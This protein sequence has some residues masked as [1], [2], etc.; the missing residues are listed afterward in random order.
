MS[1]LCLSSFL[2]V[3]YGFGDGSLGDGGCNEAYSA[4][5]DTVFRA[6]ATTFVSLTWFALFLAWE[7]VSARRSFFLARPG[8]KHRVTQWARDAWRNRFLFW[9]IVAGFVTVFPTIY[10]PVLNHRVFKH[11][12]ISWEWGVVFAEAAVFFLGC[13]AWKWAKRVFFRRRE[14]RLGHTPDDLEKLAFSEFTT[15]ERR[16]RDEFDE[17][18]Q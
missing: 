2:L 4:A 14:R 8:S 3:V 18:K 12:P 9:A 7:M 1:L 5:C 11:A 10:I 15:E 17:G 6:R 13:E 16:C